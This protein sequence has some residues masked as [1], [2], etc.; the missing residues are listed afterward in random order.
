MN[1]KNTCENIILDEICFDIFAWGTMLIIATGLLFS[2]YLDYQ[3]PKWKKLP[4]CRYNETNDYEPQP[5][6]MRKNE[7]K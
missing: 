5:E 3:K 1:L 7:K 4:M 2:V 6:K